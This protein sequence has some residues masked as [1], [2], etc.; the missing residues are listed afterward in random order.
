ME[1]KNELLILT[2]IIELQKMIIRRLKKESMKNHIS[3]ME[4]RVE[5]LM[6]EIAFDNLRQDL[7]S[8]FEKNLKE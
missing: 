5:E 4:N 3:H 8:E 2:T 7:V 1:E 6:S